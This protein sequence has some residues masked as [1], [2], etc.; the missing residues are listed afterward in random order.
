MKKL[1]ALTVVV[2]LMS[3][4]LFFMSCDNEE[5]LQ[6]LYDIANSTEG[7]ES[8]IVLISFIDQ[9]SVESDIEE[10]FRDTTITATVFV[11]N[12]AAFASLFSISDTLTESDISA[13]ADYYNVS[14]G[15]MAGYLADI[16][17]L[18]VIVDQKLYKAD[19]IADADGEI[20]PTEWDDGVSVN[21][22]V[23]VDGETVTLTPDIG[24]STSAD[25]ITADIEAS[26]G[27]AHIIDDVLWPPPPEEE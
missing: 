11:P 7:L 15:E 10:S 8:L 20:G 24:D 12:N 21:L 3:F 27:I 22:L 4:G 9:Y 19:I 17:G 6:S 2:V 5:T 26:N 16:I 1:C 13:F 23:S 18:H 14:D 25:I